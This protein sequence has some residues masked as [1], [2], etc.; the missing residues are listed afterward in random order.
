MISKQAG[1]D[2]DIENKQNLSSTSLLPSDK[3]R[4]SQRLGFED[5]V[6]METEYECS[7]P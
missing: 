3:E 1:C 2:I 5:T 7:M 6:K 4:R